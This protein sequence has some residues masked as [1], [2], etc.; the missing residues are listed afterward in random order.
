L[1]KIVT[2]FGV[3]H[4]RWGNKVQ[5]SSLKLEFYFEIGKTSLAKSRNA[6]RCGLDCRTTLDHT[7]ATELMLDFTL[8]SL[9][10]DSGSTGDFRWIKARHLPCETILAVSYIKLLSFQYN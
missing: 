5:N 10:I 9:G 2:H 8:Q 4:L 3:T 1:L 7:S 6:P